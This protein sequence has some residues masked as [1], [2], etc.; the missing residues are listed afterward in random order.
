MF[1]LSPK[2]SIHLTLFP[3]LF[4][5]SAIVRLVD[6][7]FACSNDRHLLSVWQDL[8]RLRS[9]GEHH[10]TCF[11]QFV[12]HM[13]GIFKVYLIFLMILNSNKPF[14]IVGWKAVNDKYQFK[15]TTVFVIT[16]VYF[17]CYRSL[18]YPLWTPVQFLSH[19]CRPHQCWSQ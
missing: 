14:G 9:Y 13:N 12:H 6:L 17:N 10:T 19:S 5:H 15:R 18:S 3:S 11:D 8:L 2:Y 16:Y 1:F 4:L 7:I